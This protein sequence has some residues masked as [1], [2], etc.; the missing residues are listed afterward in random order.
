MNF[1]DG[2]YFVRLCK[3]VLIKPKEQGGTGYILPKGSTQLA[4]VA[5]M[6]S[7]SI[8]T[9]MFGAIIRNPA[10]LLGPTSPTLVCIGTYL[11]GSEVDDFQIIRAVPNAESRAVVLYDS[12]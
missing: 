7:D 8:A 6:K 2:Y 10:N 12:K 5:R 3:D 1:T 4:A 9:P 11:K